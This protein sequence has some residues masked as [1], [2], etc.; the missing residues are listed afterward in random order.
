MLRGGQVF[1]TPLKDLHQLKLSWGLPWQIARWKTKPS[2]YASYLLG[3]EGP[4]SLLS[5]LKA[6]NLAQHLSVACYDY[7]GVAS[8]LEL[9]LDLVNAYEQ[10]I[11]EAG[12]LAFA[13]ISMLRSSGV[14]TWVLEEYRHLQQLNYNFQ[15]D[16]STYSLVQEKIPE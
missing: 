12:E 5:A 10:T 16:T 8:T 6:R 14:Q 9:S 13:F 11:L 1:I 7:H 2:A 15:F 4:G 3:Q